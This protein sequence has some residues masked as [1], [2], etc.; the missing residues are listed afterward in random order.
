MKEVKIGIGGITVLIGSVDGAEIK[1]SD[2]Y[3][4]FL[5]PGEPD[6]TLKLR[7]RNGDILSFKPEDKV[8]ETGGIWN[9]YR[10]RGKHIFNCY[11]EDLGLPPYKTAVI[12]KGFKKGDIYIDKRAE[13]AGFS[14]PFGYPLDE[15]L[16]ISLLSLG[17]GMAVHSCGVDLN[18]EGILFVGAS[19]RGKSTIAKIWQKE[20]GAVIL[21]DDRIIIRKTG[22]GFWIYGTPWHG[23]FRIC[24]NGRAPLRR[25]FFIKHGKRNNAARLE[26]IDAVARLI[27]CS[28]PP[29][30][31]R[32]GMEFTLDLCSELAQKIPSYQ[33]S[34]LPNDNIVKFIKDQK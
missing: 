34:F 18:N 25:I 8:F 17:S 31:D 16:M 4:H 23:D 12:D 14:Y 33:L 7:V 29:L 20:K 21:N 19:G 28:F 1:M 10:R 3:K 26:P 22:S 2:T 11:S 24:A 9:L 13:E 27:S 5:A 15:I 30:W 32:K 6:L